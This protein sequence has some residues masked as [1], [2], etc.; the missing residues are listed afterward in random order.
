[1]TIVNTPQKLIEVM[2]HCYENQFPLFIF[3]QI[4]VG[5]S[6]LVRQFH[7][8]YVGGTLIDERAS[9]L[10]VTD[11][12]G[13]FKIEKDGTEFIPPKQY[14]DFTKPNAKGTLFLDEFNLA[15]DDVQK[16]MY[17][18]IL[19]R[20]IQQHKFSDKVFIVAA[21][22]TN[23]EVGIVNEM[24]PAL[25]NRFL[26]VYYKPS[27]EHIAD[28]L[29]EKY[30]PAEEVTSFIMENRAN[31][32]G[33]ITGEQEQFARPRNFERLLQF[34]AGKDV[35]A[36][37]N[38][39]V[40]NIMIC[41]ILGNQMGKSF[42]NSVNLYNDLNLKNLLV[43]PSRISEMK[44]ENYFPLTYKVLNTILSEKDKILENVKKYSV[45]I[46]HIK[47]SEFH[48]IFIKHLLSKLDPELKGQVYNILTKEP[49]FEWVNNI[50]K[51]L[52]EIQ[53]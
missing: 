35:H 47:D 3:G 8:K 37:V 1:M 19:D 33:E 6:Q 22:N 4:G 13:L 32:I 27:T 16:I 10:D 41:T 51:K 46:K 2:K 9:E 24:S 48:L 23:S 17:K 5:K 11:L 49:G 25:I 52:I 26:I 7:E 39:E 45:I 44:R 36:A 34:L 30:N 40:G 15:S 12:R 42:I 29:I 31:M 38:E 21:G 20:K 18:V 43:N 14:L 53:K 50:L 28:Y